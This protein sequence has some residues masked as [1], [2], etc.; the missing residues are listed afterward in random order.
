MDCKYATD[1]EKYIP[2]TRVGTYVW[3]PTCGH[4]RVGTYVWALTCGHLRV[5]TYVWACVVVMVN[6]MV[7]VI[8]M[9]NIIL[10]EVKQTTSGNEHALINVT[11]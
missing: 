7:M 11:V 10:I 6:R 2:D 8:V 1:S 3:A 9:V 5:G 4:L